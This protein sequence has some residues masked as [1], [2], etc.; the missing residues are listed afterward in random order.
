MKKFLKIT[1]IVLVILLFVAFLFRKKIYRLDFALKMFS[2][3]EQVDRFRTVEEYFPTR[4]IEQSKT[5]S[6]FTRASEEMILPESYNY[7]GTHKKTEQLLTITDV[8]GLLVIK[9]DTIQFEKYHRGNTEDSHTIAWSVTKS[10]VSALVGIALEEGHIKSIDDVAVD[11]VSE[12]KGTAYEQVSIKNLLQMSSGIRWNEDYSDFDSD[13][14]RFGRTLALGYS[15]ESFVK[16]LER[17]R[18]Q[19]TY[20]LYN[21]SDTQVLGMI[22]SRAT[23]ITLSDY[24][25][26]KIWKPI[27]ME[28]KAYWVVDDH[29]DEFAA[30]GLNASLRDYARF[31]KLYLNKGKYNGQQIVPEKWVENSLTP[32]APHLM[33]GE[34]YFG[35]G[36]QWW[37]PKTKQN[38]FLAIGVYNQFIY[39]N[40]TEN[41]IIVKS[42]AYSSY[43]TGNREDNY[44]DHET[45]ELFRAIVQKLK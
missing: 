40:P 20:N 38:E 27:G 30:A 18:E 12:L 17:D 26:A 33:P 9:N 41:V 21:S 11:Y 13:I 36:Y 22:I 15:F 10:F 8:T 1:G 39:V 28:N 7:R 34:N 6:T 44:T 23:G 37:I 29:G 35:Y 25:E 16:T 42:S 43:G 4:I 32:D 5:P 45:M 3:L 19:G 2:G 24:L 14:N 31:G